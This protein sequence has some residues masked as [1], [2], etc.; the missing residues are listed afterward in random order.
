MMALGILFIGGLMWNFGSDYPS[1]KPLFAVGKA[2]QAVVVDRLS[3]GS[4]VGLL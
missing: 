2:L 4:V 3:Q 1:L